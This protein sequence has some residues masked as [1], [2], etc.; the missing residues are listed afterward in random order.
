[1]GDK[2]LNENEVENLNEQLDEYDDEM[3]QGQE[4][5]D[6]Q[7]E[8]YGIAPSKEQSNLYSWFWKVVQL[9]EEPLEVVKTGNL[10]HT[11]VGDHE[12]SV[13]ECLNLGEL[14]VIFGHPTFGQYFQNKAKIITAT[15]MARKGWF[16]DLS[17]SQRKIRARQKSDSPSTNEKK[18]KGAGMFKKKQP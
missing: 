10:F 13:R 3:D 9:K 17:I 7:L 6:A 1:M 2:E 16:M 18:W 15:S 5:S 8:Q 12:F 4:L 11:E 14:G